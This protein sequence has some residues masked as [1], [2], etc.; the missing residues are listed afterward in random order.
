MT[1]EFDPPEDVDLDDPRFNGLGGPTAEEMQAQAAIQAT[2]GPPL[3]PEEI[4]DFWRPKLEQVSEVAP[5]GIIPPP[6]AVDPK[7]FETLLQPPKFDPD[8]PIGDI[9][10]EEYKEARQRVKAEFGQLRAE[11]IPGAYFQRTDVPVV[12]GEYQFRVEQRL[13]KEALETTNLTTVRRLDHFNKGN[14]HLDKTPSMI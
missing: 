10:P 2:L 1:N 4:P 5:D 8:G 11:Q 3:Q 6:P 14:V 12:A 9:D 13:L 7:V